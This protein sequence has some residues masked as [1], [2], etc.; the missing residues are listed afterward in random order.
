M[1]II[2][3]KHDESL[4]D[5]VECF[6]NARNTIPDILDVEIINAFQDGVSDIKIVE[7][8]TMK[9]PTSSP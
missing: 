3:Q 4:R 9:K 6:C 5:Y 8:I 7:E 2:K 1:K